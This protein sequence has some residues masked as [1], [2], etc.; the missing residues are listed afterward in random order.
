MAMQV[1]YKASFQKIGWQWASNVVGSGASLG[2]MTSLLAA[3]FSQ[4]QYIC[5]IAR[6]RLVPAWLAHVH[7]STGTSLNA[8]LFLFR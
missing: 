1:S 5:V 8:S 3:R 4:A 7:P 6:A 2:F